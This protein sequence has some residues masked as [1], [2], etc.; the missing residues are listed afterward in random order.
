MGLLDVDHRHIYS[1][2]KAAEDGSLARGRSVPFVGS[3]GS[4]SS[5]PQWWGDGRGSLALPRNEDTPGAKADYRGKAGRLDLCATVAA[6]LQWYITRLPEARLQVT[7][8]DRTGK[9]KPI[10]KHGFTTFMRG[11][12]TAPCPYYPVDALWAAT[13]IELKT[14]PTFSAYWGKIREGGPDG[15]VI[16]VK[17]IP[18]RCIRPIVPRGMTTDTY[19]E[20]YMYTVGTEKIPLRTQD[21]VR[22]REGIDLRDERSGWGALL[23]GMRQVVTLN[24]VASFTAAIMTRMGVTPVVFMGGGQYPPLSD[25]DRVAIEEEWDRMSGDAAGGALALRLPVN[26][27]QV[28]RSPEELALDR[29][30]SRPASEVCALL[31]LRPLAVGLED[32]RGTYENEK[33]ANE[34]SW[35]GGMKPLGRSL[36]AAL[37]SQLLPDFGDPDAETVSWD[38]SDV[39]ALQEDDQKKIDKATAAYESGIIFR[40]EAREAAGWEP[41]DDGLR[42]W[43]DGTVTDE[44]G[45]PVGEPEESV[46]EF[47]DDEFTDKFEDEPVNGEAEDPLFKALM[48]RGL[49]MGDALKAARRVKARKKVARSGASRKPH[50]PAKHPKDDRG[51]FRDVPGAGDDAPRK[52][53]R[54]AGPEA[55]D[56]DCPSCGL[57]V[58]KAE[59]VYAEAQEK[60]VAKA[61]G[62]K[63][64]EDNE[65]LDVRVER[66]GGGE[67]AIEVKSLLKGKKQAITV[68]ADALLRKVEYAGRN[69]DSTF[70]TVVL[71][72]RAAYEGGEHAGNFSGHG[73][74]YKR[75]SGAFALSKMH[76]VKDHAELKRLLDTPDDQLPAAARGHLPSGDAVSKLRESAAKAH[77]SRLKKDRARK[78]RL[79]AE[80]AAAQA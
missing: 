38:Y 63:Q 67:H 74:Y 18:E 30:P 29:L 33:Q 24:G 9:A 23:A 54:S 66:A 57:R 25:E 11:S 73:L 21:V 62:G 12:R 78:A 27:E 79:K 56:P 50:D 65:P 1:W 16:G 39:P 43:A 51:R 68:H 32:D 26:V 15:P 47:D 71:D 61:V 5:A 49:P 20:G 14:S 59:H 64:L 42:V 45:D 72:H 4:A 22:F 37:Q 2:L 19:I 7:R 35:N 77:E 41:I 80:K 34:I 55:K 44:E 52:G 8:E 75:G 58:G 10:P 48:S 69:P 53:R 40:D 46:D 17:W 60:A 6:C 31:G 36:A 13:I 76:R 70:H 3:Q 28:G